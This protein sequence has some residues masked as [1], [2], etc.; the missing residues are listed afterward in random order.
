MKYKRSEAEELFLTFSIELR[1]K[2][3]IKRVSLPDGSGDR[4]MF[5]GTLGRLTKLE[6]IEDILLE[7]IGDYGTFRIDITRE[8][9]EKGLKIRT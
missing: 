2:D 4:F 1:S 7:I 3:Q 8:E 9:L 5:E 6:L